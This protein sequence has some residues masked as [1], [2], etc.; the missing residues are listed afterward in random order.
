[1]IV[2]SALMPTEA[3]TQGAKLLTVEASTEPEGVGFLSGHESA[4]SAKL[5]EAEV[6]LVEGTRQIVI[7]SRVTTLRLGRCQ[8][9]K[10][11][12]ARAR[13]RKNNPSA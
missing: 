6:S 5:Y 10:A 8:L 11:A 7:D 2:V 12:L 9:N 3:P 13:K 1:M 4:S